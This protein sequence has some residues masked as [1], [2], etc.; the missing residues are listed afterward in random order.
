MCSNR[1]ACGPIQSTKIY[2]GLRNVHGAHIV[3]NKPMAKHKHA[4]NKTHIG[5]VGKIE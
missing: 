3:Q 4:H 1:L 2:S 5:K